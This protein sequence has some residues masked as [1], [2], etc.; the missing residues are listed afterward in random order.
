MKFTLKDYQD[1]AVRDV[2]KQIRKGGSRWRGEGERSAFSLTAPTGAGKTVMVA[3]VLEA[4]FHGD[5]LYDFDADKG[6]VVLWFSDSPDL[7]EQTRFRL[8]ESSDRLR[9][10]DMMVVEHPF[11]RQRFEAGK[12]YFLNTQKLG[13]KSLLV[14]GFDEETG[15]DVDPLPG[16]RPDMQAHTLWDTIRNSIEDPA[17]TMYLVL[18]EAHRGMGNVTAQALNERTTLVKRLING[19]RGVPGIPV[20]L[21][22]SATV[23]R[24]NQ[25]M[26]GAKGRDTLASV[27][28]DP[29]RVRE[30]GLLKDTLLL[31]VP[32]EAG[33]FETQLLRRGTEKLR[34]ATEEW[35]RY[36]A[37]QGGGEGVVPLMVL[38]VP[39][40]PVEAEVAT[41][42]R[43]IF[44]AWPELRPDSV[45]NVFGEHKEESYGPY[46][47]PYIEPQRVQES[48]WVRVL[49]AK[50]AISTGWDCPRAEVMVSFRR[51]VDET[52]IRQLLGRMVRSPLARRIP[53]NDRLNSVSCLL[54]HFDKD[55]VQKVVTALQS[56][57]AGSLSFGR[58]L[59]HSV[60]VKAAAGVPQALW[61]RFTSLPTQTLP[62]KGAKPPIRLTALAQELASDGLLEKAGAKAHRAMHE[63][64]DAFVG[65]REIEFKAQLQNVRTF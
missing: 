17:L 7:N 14:R 57:E 29:V 3:A 58:A 22:I 62:Q 36:A 30:S 23:E 27:E 9:R 35:A 4:L 37:S 49:L 41:W 2:L 21:G 51:A 24:F 13:K 15:G 12:I 50:D 38:Q 64:L 46:K 5:D 43:T 8:M 48:T 28:V 11:S 44:E 47:V 32:D 18:D 60:E 63:T 52:H 34:D 19:E 1:D 65:S 26:A 59:V 53:G 31:D 6:A 20:V 56:G 40:T 25:A 45:A 55:A 61:K 33:Q 39:N 10:T 54:P 16:M 42:L